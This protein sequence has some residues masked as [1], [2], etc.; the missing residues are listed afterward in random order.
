MRLDMTRE[1]LNTNH[2]YIQKFSTE[3]F[4]LQGENTYEEN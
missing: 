2:F 3:R 4:S 1:I